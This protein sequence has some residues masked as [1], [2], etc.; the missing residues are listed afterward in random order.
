M[1][2]TETGLVRPMAGRESR[3]FAGKIGREVRIELTWLKTV[4]GS[5]EFWTL[6]L[7]TLVL[8][9]LAYQVSR[10]YS[11][12]IGGGYDDAYVDNFHS[13]EAGAGVSY[14]WTD[15][16]SYIRLPG[17]GGGI[18]FQLQLRV[19]SGRPAGEPAPNLEIIVNGQAMPAIKLGPGW[20][21]YSYDITGPAAQSRDLVVELRSDTYHPEGNRGL[22]LG[23][24]VDWV[25]YRPTGA[26][27]VFPSLS[28]LIYAMLAVCVVYATGRRA[29]LGTTTKGWLIRA[30]AS[31]AGVAM[32]FAIAYTV[33]F[34]RLDYTP[35]AKNLIL[36]LLLGLALLLIGE[37]LI[38]WLFQA[39]RLETS[40]KHRRILLA[41][42]LVAFYA[43][44]GGLAYPNMIMI[45]LPWHMRFLRMVLSGQWA[46]LYFPSPLSS[47]PSE[48]N[49][50]VLI[51]KSPLFYFIA[52]P[53]SFLPLPIE[54]S[55]K[56][57]VTLLDVSLLFGIFYLVKKF[58]GSPRAALF[59]AAVYGF[60]PLT[61]RM[62]SYGILPTI[63]AQWLTVITFA[64][65]LTKFHNLNRAGPFAL[66]TMLLAAT[67]VAF[68]T[69][70]VFNTI[71]MGIWGVSMLLWPAEAWE[72][73]RVIQLAMVVVGGLVVAFLS[74]Y[75][76]YLIPLLTVTLPAYASR[77]TTGSG[78]VVGTGGLVSTVQWSLTFY[79][80][81]LPFVGAIFG[82]AL[83][84]VER[85]DRFWLL[86]IAWL[87]IPVVFA[88]VGMHVDMIGKHLFYAMVPL[89][90][91]LGILLD[92]LSSR[93][94]AGR[95]T[96][97]MLFATLAWSAVS[98]WIFRI[99]YA[100]H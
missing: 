2:S 80:S 91:G 62:L 35:Y 66:T 10:P 40:E 65:I 1:P 95:I 88:V 98:F 13:K 7:L 20:Q 72:R 11:V 68:P 19:A 55:V 24:Q 28:Q 67:M 17:I 50:D 75:M 12:D 43:K 14:R 78:Q 64:I 34:Q 6:A 90:I 30:L 53:V 52:A 70:L 82:L 76:Q 61:Y 32:L 21:T 51:P 49:M 54:L 31:I 89:S 33:A 73:R 16:Y 58:Y 63:F 37:R 23:T 25:S 4:L 85:L 44:F 56:L 77:L 97:Y 96:G 22:Q 36:V 94:V 79:G 48:W 92:R 8:T 71:V 18:P 27:L 5:W 41:V 81:A 26:G 3:A 57:F 42:A 87:T 39:V 84:R 99:L 93:G 69:I 15:N 45:D 29:V 83:Y 74:Y 100:G 86:L 60:T 59:A 9:M 38:R 47:V 46:E